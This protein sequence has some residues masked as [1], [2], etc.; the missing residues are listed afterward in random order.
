MKIDDTVLLTKEEEAAKFSG[1]TV[2]PFQGREG[3]IEAEP[4]P[5]IFRV[6]YPARIEGG[7]S[8]AALWP[9]EFLTLVVPPEPEPELT[10]EQRIHRI[11]LHLGFAQA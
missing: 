9:A 6:R 11:E 4:Y 2:E 10:L 8:S 1:A 7:R 5:G 3:V